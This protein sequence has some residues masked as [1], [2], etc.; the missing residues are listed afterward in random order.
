M[1]SLPD[2]LRILARQGETERMGVYWAGESLLGAAVLS[3]GRVLG[4]M[5]HTKIRKDRRY[6]NPDNDPRGPYVLSDLTSPFER[7]SLQYEWHGRLPPPGRSWR[8]SEEK[9]QAL[10]AEGR[11]VYSATGQPRLKRYLNEV[12]KEEPTPEVP[13]TLQLDFIIRTAMK[14]IARMIAKHPISLQAVE[15]RDL[16]RVLREVFESLGFTVELTR[17]GKDGGFDLKL[18]CKDTSG[19]RFS[20]LR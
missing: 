18:Q 15:W 2:K 4:Y 20:W 7:R 16:E 13:L 11:I 8:Y 1:S 9:L 12:G 6:K 17:S 10:E 19:V 3:S 14:A 5:P